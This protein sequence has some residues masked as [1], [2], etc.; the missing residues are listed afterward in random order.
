MAR[1]LQQI[2]VCLGLGGG[3]RSP[4]VTTILVKFDLEISIM[5]R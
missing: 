3:L 2:K 1:G 5:T 4:R